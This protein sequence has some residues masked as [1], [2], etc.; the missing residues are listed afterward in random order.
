[1]AALNLGVI[2]ALRQHRERLRRLVAR[3]HLHC[4]PVDGA[5]VKPRRRSGLEPPERESQSLQSQ[6]QAKRRRFP[7]ASRRRLPLADMDAPAQ[8]GS[9]REHDRPCPKLPSVHQFEPG[10]SLPAD[11]EVVRLRFDHHEVRCAA[12]RLLHGP[13]VE[14][15]VRLRARPTHGGALATVEHTAL[16]AGE[17]GP[18]PHKAVARVDLTDEM[19]LAE[20]PNRRIARHRTDGREAMG[21]ER[22]LGA[23]ARGGRGGL[24]TGMA[25]THDDD[26]VLRVHHS[27][28]LRAPSFY[29]T[30]GGASIFTSDVSVQCV[31]RETSAS[32]AFPHRYVRRYLPIQKSR[33][34]TSRTSSTSTRPR[35]LPNALVARRS[36]SAMISSRPSCAA[37]C[38]PCNASTVSLRCAR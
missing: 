24:A 2:D 11:Y 30:A 5:A 19:A 14:P 10:D 6:R 13:G 32:H 21:D 8:E 3:L 9:R 29:P 26:V 12:D 23:H 16:D 22:D 33:K 27:K 34:I 20:A 28:F 36:C 25:A 38:A 4:G 1:N 35:S 18:T 7:N 37:R 15:A 31:S 17:I